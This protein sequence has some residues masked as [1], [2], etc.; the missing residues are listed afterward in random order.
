MRCAHSAGERNHPDLIVQIPQDYALV[1]MRMAFIH[2]NAPHPVAAKVFMN[3]LLSYAGQKIL[4]PR[5]Q[6][7]SRAQ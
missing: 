3:F 6:P 1:M 7:H 5:V 2:R 4:A